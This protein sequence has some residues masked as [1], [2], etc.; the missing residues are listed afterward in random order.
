MQYKGISQMHVWDVIFCEFQDFDL[1][2][3]SCLEMPLIYYRTEV[4]QSSSRALDGATVSTK[5]IWEKQQTWHMLFCFYFKVEQP[6]L[7]GTFLCG[8]SRS[9]VSESRSQFIRFRPSSAWCQRL[10][11]EDE[12]DEHVLCVSW[13]GRVWL[14]LLVS[15]GWGH[16]VPWNAPPPTT[17]VQSQVNSLHSWIHACEKSS[18]RLMFFI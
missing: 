2:G 9:S 5:R 13:G 8:R 18:C 12:A 4:M 11:D 14:E 16:K 3:V 1:S 10:C 6:E 7:W 15:F 17:V